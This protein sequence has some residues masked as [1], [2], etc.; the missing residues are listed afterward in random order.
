MVVA[1]R[2]E[3]AEDVVHFLLRVSLARNGSDLREVDL[4]SQFR[5]VLVLVYREAVRAQDEVY[6]LP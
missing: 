5:L 6:G 4:V 2:R 1:G 3:D